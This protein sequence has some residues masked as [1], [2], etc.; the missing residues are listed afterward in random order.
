MM[1]I[2]LQSF[3][4]T[5]LTSKKLTNEIKQYFDIDIHPTSIQCIL[6]KFA[7]W[8]KMKSQ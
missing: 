5:D 2:L 7:Y 8:S 4:K 3:K 1:C 6:I